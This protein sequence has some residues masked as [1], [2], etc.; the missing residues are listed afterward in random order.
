M[1]PHSHHVN[2]RLLFG[3]GSPC[4]KQHL[5]CASQTRGVT[6]ASGRNWLAAPA[7]RVPSAAPA[8]PKLLPWNCG[9][10]C[11][12]P[13]AC[14]EAAEAT[15]LGQGGSAGALGFSLTGS[16]LLSLGSSGG[17][18][19]CGTVDVTRS[20]FSRARACGGRCPPA[21]VD[22]HPHM[23]RNNVPVRYSSSKGKLH[24]SNV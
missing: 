5:P 21:C 22:K 20:S 3:L 1:L 13:L 24:L 12:R 7:E 23:C 9:R 16:R 10:S 17:S 8:T 11:G 19:V 2:T 18:L 4:G 15:A 14:G 6:C